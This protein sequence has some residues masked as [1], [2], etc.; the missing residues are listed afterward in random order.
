MGLWPMPNHFSACRH[1]SHNAPFRPSHPFPSPSMMVSAANYEEQGSRL[2][3][4]MQLAQPTDESTANV[5]A[6]ERAHVLNVLMRI[7]AD[8][9]QG[10]LLV[11]F[12]NIH[13]KFPRCIICMY[14]LAP[15]NKFPTVPLSPLFPANE[16]H[17]VLVPLMCNTVPRKAREKKDVPRY[18]GDRKRNK[19]RI[20]ARRSLLSLLLAQPKVLVEKIEEKQ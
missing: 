3:V 11:Y 20:R 6:Y 17:A 19:Y 8:A 16:L 12:V 14:C 2:Q 9:E 18:P 10:L 4:D 15:T 13:M 5:A 1:T 7:G